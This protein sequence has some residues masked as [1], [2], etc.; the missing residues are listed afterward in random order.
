M[1]G[2]LEPGSSGICFPSANEALIT[3]SEI[4]DFGLIRCALIICLSTPFRNL[5]ATK[6]GKRAMALC[7]VCASPAGNTPTKPILHEAS[8][9]HLRCRDCCHCTPRI[10]R[11]CTGLEGSMD[12][13]SLCVPLYLLPNGHRGWLFDDGS[14]R[15]PASKSE[16]IRRVI[17]CAEHALGRGPVDILTS[18]LFCASRLSSRKYTRIRLADG[19]VCPYRTSAPS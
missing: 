1:R 7:R 15:E 8:G 13:A 6:R 19:C 10:L 14:K 18:F 5:D 17:L 11:G 4:D 9:C 16:T 3:K 2:K 12:L